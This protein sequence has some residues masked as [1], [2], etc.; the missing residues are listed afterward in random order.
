VLASGVV[1]DRRQ[2]RRCRRLATVFNQG[3][4]VDKQKIILRYERYEDSHCW[5]AILQDNSVA[6]HIWA[7]GSVY[8][9][10]Y[11]GVEQHVKP[12]EGEKVDHEKCPFLLGPCRHDGSSLYFVERFKD[13]A[14]SAI[15]DQYHDDMLRSAE[16]ELLRRIEYLKEESE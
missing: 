2:S 13:R 12:K 15:V 1:S 8:G 14:K 6:V 4:T 3:A 9:K 10:L 11:G 16:C 7:R 5:A